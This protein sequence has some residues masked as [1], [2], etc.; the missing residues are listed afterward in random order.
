MI[1][2]ASETH[3]SNANLQLLVILHNDQSYIILTF[4]ERNFNHK[5][6]ILK[7]KKKCTGILKKPY[8]WV[9]PCKQTCTEAL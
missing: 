1:I 7:D 5:F 8:T 4:L 6:A 2:K 3:Y 9:V